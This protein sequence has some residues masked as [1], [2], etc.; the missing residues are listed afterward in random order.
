MKAKFKSVSKI[1][2]ITFL[3]MLG[4]VAGCT[5]LTE[6]NEIRLWNVL[7]IAWII[8]GVLALGCVAIALVLDAVEA[9]KKDK[10]SYLLGL[11]WTLVALWLVILVVEYFIN[12][13]GWQLTTAFWK[14]LVILGGIRAGNYIFEK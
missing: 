10:V 5:M 11:L 2:L 4:I 7:G 3:M 12:H 6:G 1:F 8:S 13:N 14:G 9:W